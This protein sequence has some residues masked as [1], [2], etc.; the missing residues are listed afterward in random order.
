[1]GPDIY[2]D[3]N[4]EAN[5]NITYTAGLNTE[6]A[7]EELIY[8]WVS[9]CRQQFTNQKSKSNYCME[10]D[11]KHIR[12]YSKN[13]N[14]VRFDT[15]MN[16]NINLYWRTM[17]GFHFSSFLSEI[18][19]Y[20]RKATWCKINDVHDRRLLTKLNLGICEL[21]DNNIRPPPYWIQ[22]SW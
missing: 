19:K 15:H 8:I 17:Q 7:R 13:V 11:M 14:P 2:Y 3:L 10:T 5:V 18:L 22:C 6:G 16:N 1:M 9:I 20:E 21:Q 12:I 4:T